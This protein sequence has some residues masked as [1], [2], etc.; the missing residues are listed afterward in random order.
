MLSLLEFQAVIHKNRPYIFHE[1]DHAKRIQNVIRV[2]KIILKNIS[3]LVSRHPEDMYDFIIN[4][5]DFVVKHQHDSELNEFVDPS[6]QLKF[7]L[8][9]LIETVDTDKLGYETQRYI[10]YFRKMIRSENQN[11]PKR[12]NKKVDYKIR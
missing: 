6:N 11:R 9:C 2:Y 12:S 10:F 3:D 8:E 4:T 5:Y 7:L 1:K